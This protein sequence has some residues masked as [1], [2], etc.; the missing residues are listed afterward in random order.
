MSQHGLHV[1]IHIVPAVK[2]R[3]G[4]ASVASLAAG[5]G[6][7]ECVD[8]LLIRTPA[9]VALEDDFGT[10]LIRRKGRVANDVDHE[11]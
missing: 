4:N 1:R 6:C 11:F 7:D 8:F 10:R 9:K 3:E 2:T 5:E